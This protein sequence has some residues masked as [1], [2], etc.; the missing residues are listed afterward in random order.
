[1]SG[2]FSQSLSSVET[3]RLNMKA[4]RAMQLVTFKQGLEDLR[5]TFHFTIDGCGCCGSPWIYDEVLREIVEDF[6]YD[7][8]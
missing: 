7:G 2:K 6:K 8:T 4:A 5:K 3:D 1:M